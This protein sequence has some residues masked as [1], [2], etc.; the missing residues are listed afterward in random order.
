M[1]KANR[2][3]SDTSVQALAAGVGRAVELFY[4]IARHHYAYIYVLGLALDSNSV[5]SQALRPV[6]PVHR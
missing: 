2:A 1:G 3:V 6:H 4:P 5:I